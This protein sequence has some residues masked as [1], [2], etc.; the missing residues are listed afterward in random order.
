MEFS[1]HST[2]SRDTSLGEYTIRD[3]ST[4]SPG[5]GNEVGSLSQDIK[6]T[7]GQ[8]KVENQSPI[9]LQLKISYEHAAAVI[10]SLC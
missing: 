10:Y 1:S 9:A 6:L 5:D 2:A 8:R 7:S 3:G 4:L